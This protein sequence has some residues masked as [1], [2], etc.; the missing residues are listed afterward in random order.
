MALLSRDT[1]ARDRPSGRVASFG[2]KDSNLTFKW[3]AGQDSY[4]VLRGHNLDVARAVYSATSWL[5]N[6]NP[7]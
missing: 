2:S 5:Q 7:R 3:G 1:N 6:R 4:T